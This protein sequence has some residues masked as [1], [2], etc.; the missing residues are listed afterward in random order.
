MS[1]FRA[2][3]SPEGTE[4]GRG[5][6]RGGYLATR[7]R[8]FW[9]LRRREAPKDLIKGRLRRGAFLHRD[10]HGHRGRSPLLAGLPAQGTPMTR[11][12]LTLRRLEAL[13][14]TAVQN[15]VRRSAAVSASNDADQRRAV[16]DHFVHAA[17]VVGG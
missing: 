14:G 2:V 9:V 6:R 11:R 13:V 1:C 5:H 16:V 10:G 12:R 17:D 4:G 3:G 15:P 8:G 7:Q